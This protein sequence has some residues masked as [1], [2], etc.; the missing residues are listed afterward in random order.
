MSKERFQWEKYW[1]KY[2]LKV[3]EHIDCPD[4]V[5]LEVD[6]SERPLPCGYVGWH[7]VESKRFTNVDA[8]FTYLGQKYGYFRDNSIKFITNQEPDHE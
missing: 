6:A 3:T 7:G 5:W 2:L 4:T 1:K 8:A